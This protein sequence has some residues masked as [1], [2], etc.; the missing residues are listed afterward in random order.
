MKSKNII[1]LGVI[2]SIAVLIV[3]GTIAYS[4]VNDKKEKGKDT[5][6]Y[7]TQQ[8]LGE[9]DAPIHVVEFGDFKCPACRTWDATVLPRLKEDYINKGKVQLHFINFPFIG[10]DSDLGAAAG[11]AIYKQDP[12]AFWTFYD[13][14][15]QKQQNEQEEWITEDLLVDIV[16]QKLPSIDITEFKKDLNSKEVK[17]KVQKD[18]DLAQKLKVQGAPSIY[19]NG[20]LVNP[21]YDSIKAAIDKESKK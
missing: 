20:K 3:I 17:D 14:I 8:S 18:L 1:I 15:Y 5:F 4:I 13:E 21:D 9:K 19:V 16:K 6:L 7:G 11:E 2:F 10:K 12:K